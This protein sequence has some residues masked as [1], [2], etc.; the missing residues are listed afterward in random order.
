MI[1]FIVESSVLP[2]ERAAPITNRI[3]RKNQRVIRSSK[4]DLDQ[5]ERI[6]LNISP[7]FTSRVAGILQTSVD[8]G[9]P[10][11]PRERNSGAMAFVFIRWTRSG[12]KIDEI[13]HN[14]YMLH[15]HKFGNKSFMGP[16]RVRNAIAY[17]AS[18]CRVHL[19]V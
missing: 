18:K 5:T 3:F 8:D 4:N 14:S 12:A 9:S 7:I 10:V 11:N 16:I 6:Y 1:H 13:L 17:I 19:G 2:R 15:T